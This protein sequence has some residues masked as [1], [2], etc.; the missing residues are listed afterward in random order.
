MRWKS[1]FVQLAGVSIGTPRP[2]EPVS[3]STSTVWPP[4][5]LT[6]AK[7]AHRCGFRDWFVGG[8]VRGWLRSIDLGSEMAGGRWWREP[9]TCV[10]GYEAC[11]GRTCSVSIATVVLCMFPA[12]SM[13]TW[14]SGC[15]MLPCPCVVV[16]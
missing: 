7:Y 8:V 12:A 14:M 2:A 15:S 3:I 9:E 11:V 6:E 10:R 4:R 1:R 16:V 13:S 5:K